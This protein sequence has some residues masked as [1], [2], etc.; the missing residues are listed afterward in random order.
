[1]RRETTQKKE[2]VTLYVRVR[3]RVQTDRHRK[4]CRLLLW[5]SCRADTA[6]REE[7]F[8]QS[9]D[10]RMTSRLPPHPPMMIGAINGL[11]SSSRNNVVDDVETNVWFCDEKFGGREAYLLFNLSPGVC[12]LVFSCVSNGFVGTTNVDDWRIC[13]GRKS[14]P[15]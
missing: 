5:N 11:M 14:K 13:D 2:F 9:T 12:F 15:M 6:W 8:H 1:M 4:H 10:H 7:V 3:M